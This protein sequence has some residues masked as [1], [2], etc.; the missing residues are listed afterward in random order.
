MKQQDA[1]VA[2]AADEVV[3]HHSGRKPS[4]RAVGVAKLCGKLV[5]VAHGLT[6]GIQKEKKTGKSVNTTHG[7]T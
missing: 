1:G 3:V 2:A 7:T 6:H 5:C 4:E